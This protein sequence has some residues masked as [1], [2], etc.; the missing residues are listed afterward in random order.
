MKPFAGK[1]VNHNNQSFGQKLAGGVS[2]VAGGLGAIKQIY[3]AGA[4][5]APYVMGAA[6]IASALI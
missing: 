1:L 6:R 2:A 5:I 4:T 3:D